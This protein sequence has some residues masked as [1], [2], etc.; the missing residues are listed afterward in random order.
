MAFA[1]PRV[2]PTSPI[3]RGPNPTHIEVQICFPRGVARHCTPP[4]RGDGHSPSN[5]ASGP[6]ATGRSGYPHNGWPLRN[7]TICGYPHKQRGSSSNWTFSGYP[8]KNSQHVKLLVHQAT[9]HSIAIRTRRSISQATGHSTIRTGTYPSN[10]T[11]QT[12]AQE[13]QLQLKGYM[14]NR[15]MACIFISTPSKR[16][17]FSTSS[18][19]DWI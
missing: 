19:V 4:E 13:S 3:Y 9:G 11:L 8:H 15:T 14:R 12:S 10:W 2:L 18:Q 16:A 17:G 5:L 6:Q 1:V 7:W